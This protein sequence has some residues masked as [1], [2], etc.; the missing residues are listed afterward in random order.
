MSLNEPRIFSKKPVW[1]DLPE[2]ERTADA[3]WFRGRLGRRIRASRV[4]VEIYERR[5]TERNI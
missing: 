4:E 5:E 3:V 1:A 2:V